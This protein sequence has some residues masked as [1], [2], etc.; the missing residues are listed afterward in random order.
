MNF[1]QLFTFLFAAPTFE[2]EDLEG[3]RMQQIIAAVQHCTSRAD[4]KKSA[5][6]RRPII[7]SGTGSMSSWCSARSAPG[8]TTP[9]D[10]WLSADHGM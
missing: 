6:C 9:P 7:N 3:L 10:V 5:I 8:G 1:V 4:L 2:S